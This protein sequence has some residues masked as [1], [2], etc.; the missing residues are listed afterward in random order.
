[1]PDGNVWSAL[2]AQEKG[3]DVRIAVDVIRM[4]RQNEFDVAVI[5]SQDQDFS[6]LADE[7]RTLGREQGRWIK[8]ASAFPVSPTSRNKRGIN[9]TEWIRIDRATYNACLDHKDY[10]PKC[11][12]QTPPA[13]DP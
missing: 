13:I 4:A 6:E 11:G 5:F 1:M 7:L 9:G 12:R 2:V 10:R 3:I 8:V